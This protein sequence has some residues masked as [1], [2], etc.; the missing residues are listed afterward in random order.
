M[1]VKERLRWRKT[2]TRIN[3]TFHYAW[4][5]VWGGEK[6]HLDLHRSVIVLYGHCPLALRI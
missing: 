4:Q 6:D 1:E 2:A 3:L 5:G